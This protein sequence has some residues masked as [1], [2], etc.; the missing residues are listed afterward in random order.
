MA[1]GDLSEKVLESVEESRRSFL[2]KLILNTAFVAPAVASFSMSGLGVNEALA[3]CSNLLCSN[4]G[5]DCSLVGTVTGNFSGCDY[6]GRNLH[7][8]NYPTTASWVPTLPGRTFPLPISIARYF[9]EP[10]WRV[11]I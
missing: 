5:T 1:T 2:M 6:A 4:Q 3:N 8:M 9:L 10:T 11:L 7:R